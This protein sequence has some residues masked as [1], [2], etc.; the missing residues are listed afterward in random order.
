[1][2]ENWS[3]TIPFPPSTANE[4]MELMEEVITELG[5]TIGYDVQA[6]VSNREDQKLYARPVKK[7]NTH[8]KRLYKLNPA[9]RDMI[10]KFC[11]LGR[12][13]LKKLGLDED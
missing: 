12:I 9:A 2:K 8:L 1:M 4:Y 6:D 13:S 5:N 10:N 3:K 11:E 7:D